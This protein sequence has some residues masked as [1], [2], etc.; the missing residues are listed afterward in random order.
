MN[1]RYVLI[2]PCRDE[3][4][5]VQHTIDTV[6]AQSVQP[7]KWVIVDDGSS[8]ATPEILARAAREHPFIEIVR[9]ENRGER[10]VG[11]GVIDAFNAGLER[12]EL[13]EYGY[14]CK[15]DADLELPPRYFERL[16]EHCE[17]DSWLGTVSGKLLV[18]S[19]DRFVE[20]RCGDENSIGP[21]KFYRVDCF[22]DIGG[23]ARQVCWDGIDG[24]L[25]RM[26]NW[27]AR[28]IDEPILHV[29]HLR[30]MG[31]S[32]KGLWT[33]RMRWGRGKYIMGSRPYYVLPVAFYRMLERPYV[34]GGL[35]ILCGYLSA[36]LRH[37]PRYDDPAYLK[38]LRRYELLSLVQGKR[39]TMERYH[40][41]IRAGSPHRPGAAVR[42]E[43]GV[44]VPSR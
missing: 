25:C 40:E 9:R 44:F 24:H 21:T 31:S 38:F 32:H 12:V 4:K 26:K 7:A 43:A 15:L 13:S 6:V 8:D 39:R 5:Y 3:A 29:I 30:R 16:M 1:R 23:F 20:E 35:G 27:M 36:W 2:T 37:L 19:G 42:R 10:A 17:A 22:Q 18:R 28:S 14:V 11:P 41:R 34:I 33:G